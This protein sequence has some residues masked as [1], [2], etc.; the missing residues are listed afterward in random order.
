VGVYRRGVDG[1]RLRLAALVLAAGSGSRFSDAPGAKLLAEID[2]E[3]M[4]TR[5]LRS[6]RAFGPTA[7]VVVLG[8]GADAVEQAVDW[9][10]EIRVRNHAPERGLSSSLHVGIDMLRA[11]PFDIDGV[12]IVLG[13]Q[14][15]LDAAVMGSLAVAAAGGGAVDWPS[16]RSSER[17]GEP[18]GERLT[19]RPL[20][21]PRYTE[22]PGPRNPVLLLRPGWHLL[23]GLS[24]DHGLSQLMSEQPQLVLDVSVPGRMPDVDKPEDLLAVR[25]ARTRR[26][27][28]T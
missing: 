11:L 26:P 22:Q 1:H 9:Q 27:S 15:L 18:L 24:G 17:P 6:V 8:S 13:D 25:D 10:D 4:L 3:P 5:V 16:E 20:I 12:F 21:V 14:P 23:D 7:T 19:E 28:G 2:G